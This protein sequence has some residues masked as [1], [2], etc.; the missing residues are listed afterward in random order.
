MRK[1]AE[2]RRDRGSENREDEGKG[3]TPTN[4][5]TNRR[6]THFLRQPG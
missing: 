2:E 3:E 1:G 5:E 6:L 4:F